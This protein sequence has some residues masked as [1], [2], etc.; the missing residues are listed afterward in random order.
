MIQ[1]KP[2]ALTRVCQWVRFYCAEV[3][4]ALEYLHSCGFI[5]RSF[6]IE[7]I[8][9]S[10]HSAEQLGGLILLICSVVMKALAESIDTETSVWEPCVQIHWPDAIFCVLC[11]GGVRDQG[12]E[13]RKYS[14]ASD[15]PPDAYRLRS[16][17]AGEKNS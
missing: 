13:T 15:W 10:E 11:L 1:I 3:L 16:L 8:V 17:K 5:Y 7:S 9:D 12:S 4:L 2:K 6:L 14:A